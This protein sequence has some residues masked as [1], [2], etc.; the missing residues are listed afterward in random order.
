[1]GFGWR[2]I[3]FLV[4]FL[5]FLLP[6]RSVW[7]H[8]VGQPPFL[9]VNGGYAPFYDVSLGSNYFNLPQDKAPN[10]YLVNQA[11]DFKID[12]TA[13]QVPIA[14]ANETV[15]SW[16][17]GDG[18]KVSG[19]EFQHTYSHPGSYVVNITASYKNE[20][21]TLIESCY[22]NVLPSPSY[23][24][25]EPAISVNGIKV[26][27]PLNTVYKVDFSQPVKFGGSLDGA[28]GKITK[29]IWDFK[30]GTSASGWQ[31]NHQFLNSPEDTV[32]ILHVEDDL[33][34]FHDAYAE[35]QSSSLTNL[36]MDQNKKV[37]TISNSSSGRDAYGKVTSRPLPGNFLDSLNYQMNIFAR[38]NINSWL[39]GR[40]SWW[41]VLLI[42]PLVAIAG[43]LHALTPGHGKSLMAAYLI[44]KKGSAGKD[45][46]LLALTITFTHTF[47]IF[48]LGFFFLYINQKQ[49]LTSLLP[50]FQKGS[51]ILVLLIGLGL[52]RR[53]LINWKREFAHHD[54]E[55]VHGHESIS[56]KRSIF[57]AGFS[58][59]IIPCGDALAILLLA[60]SAGQLVLGLI[61]VS[62]F[63]LGLGLTIVGLG[64]LFVFGKKITLKNERLGVIAET[65]GPMVTGS[66]LLII[67]IHF[68]V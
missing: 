35:V 2:I 8:A 40:L 21:P 37:T 3:F 58:G 7:A 9:L 57:F 36:A 30:D 4:T 16:D 45:V 43:G 11:V 68:F 6:A 23:Q 46:G 49:D 52:L 10:N 51:A 47:L 44:G 15:F 60:A 13:L 41:L 61:L 39:S 27:D 26:I 34:F 67:S 19:I 63:S 50:I 42:F 33:G 25:P 65:Y 5:F 64:L 62:F 17:F 32:V 38:N 66:F 59:G 18:T 1:M 56:K 55:H 12:K 48:A 53:G 54:H 24:P 29:I 14:V 20:E 22:L 28:S 31:V